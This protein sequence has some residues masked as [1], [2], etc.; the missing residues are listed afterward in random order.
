MRYQLT[1]VR[2]AIIKK[3]TNNKCWRGCGEK[4][5]LLY[6]LWEFIQIGKFIQPI[7]RTVWRFLK[8]TRNKT[9][10]RPAIQLLGIY[11]EEIQI[12]KV[13]CNPIFPWRRSWQPTPVFLLGVSPWTEEPGGLQSMELQ[14][15]RNE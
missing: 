3:S 7:W 1:V 6:C 9:T 15:V 11:F 2:M 5:I 4:G 12:E 10:P 8:K 14:R 13:T